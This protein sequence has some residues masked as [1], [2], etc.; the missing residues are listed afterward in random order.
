MDHTEALRMVAP[1]RDRDTPGS[2]TWRR[3]LVAFASGEQ[4][5]ASQV[6]LNRVRADAPLLPP[7][8]E[9]LLQAEQARS[10]SFVATGPG[11]TLH[12]VRW[13]DRDADLTV[14]AVSEEVGRDVLEVASRDAVDEPA[15]TDGSVVMGFWHQSDGA[16]RTERNI[17]ASPWS[18][19]R[20][21]YASS[22]AS[23]L[24]RLLTCDPARLSGR[25]VLLHGPPGTGKTTLLRALAYA[26]RS[27]CQVDYVLD[28]DRLLSSPAYLMGVAVDDDHLDD[29]A[30][31]NAA[32]WKLLVLEDCDELIRAEAKQGAGQNLARLLNLTDGLV[33]QGL[34]VLVCITTNEE[35]SRL[36][37][38]VTRPGRCLAQIHVGRLPRA[39]AAAWL[40]TS[41]GIGPEGST[42]AELFARRGDLEQITQDRPDEPVGLYL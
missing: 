4:P 31:G 32:R 21:N 37:P 19:I 26:W 23:S 20:A 8:V 15:L 35:L 5:W 40:G 17:Q 11:W 41:D 27:W 1:V 29:E 22:V 38:A 7:G 36:H 18:R 16:R 2:L 42:L 12:V 30:S 24:E 6:R 14:T 28:P 39:E 25:L 34:D 10:T 33:G 9:P 13:Q 3:G